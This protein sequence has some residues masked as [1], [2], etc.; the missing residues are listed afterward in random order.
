MTQARC[1]NEQQELTNVR[2]GAHDEIFQVGQPVLVGV[3]TDSTYCYLLSQEEQRDGATWGV[4]LLELQDQGFRPDAVV[5]DRGSGWRAG[6]ELA[7]PA[8]PQRG[9]VFH[10]LYAVKPLVLTLDNRAYEALATC[11]QLERQLATKQRRQ[12]RLD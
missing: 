10:V 3:D 12:G 11:G 4:R 6:H 2:I 5:S 7:L 1:L 8:V 9:D